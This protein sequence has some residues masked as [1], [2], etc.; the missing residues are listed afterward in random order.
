MEKS[1]DAVVFAFQTYPELVDSLFRVR[2]PAIKMYRH[3]KDRRK[4]SNL[5]YYLK[6]KGYI[7]IKIVKDK[8]AIMLTKGGINMALRAGFR[9]DK[10]KRDDGKWT[11]LIFDVPE[12]HRNLRSLLRSVL[13]NLGYKILQKS[14]WVSPYDVSDKTEEY[15]SLYNLDSYVKMF[16][17]EELPE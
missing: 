16:L 7:K 4:F 3:K 14:V 17:I 8:K 1:E 10:K 15:L 5:I 12:K 9:L 6:R 13:S 2:N 11:M